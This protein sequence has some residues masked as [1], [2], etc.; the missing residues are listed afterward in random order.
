MDNHSLIN[1][2]VSGYRILDLIGKGGMGTVYRGMHTETGQQV[3]VK[4]LHHPG[5]S[6]RFIN[7]AKLHALLKHRNIAR[8]YGY[9]LVD[10]LPCIIMEYIE[11]QGLQDFFQ[12]NTKIPVEQSVNYFIQLCSAI[13]YLHEKDI[14]HRDIKPEN[15][16]VQPNQELKL[17]D[18]GIAKSSYSPKLTLAGFTVGTVDFMAPEHIRGK[19]EKASDIWSLGVI[20][21]WMLS[22]HLPFPS[23]SIPESKINTGMGRYPPVTKYLSQ[24]TREIDS[25]IASCL[26]QNPDSRANCEELLTQVILL[27]KDLASGNSE[28]GVIKPIKWFKSLNLP[29]WALPSIL[30]VLAILA[31]II[32]TKSPAKSGKSIVVQDSALIDSIKINVINTKN[33]TIVFPDQSVYPVPFTLKG[34]KDEQSTF[35]ITAPGFQDMPVTIDLNQRRK[36]F[37]YVLQKEDK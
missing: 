28:I 24:K 7:E 10:G 23:A 1:R 29:S 34:T 19:P 15:I 9:D 5:M 21:Y 25:I 12:N 32:I 37:E 20:L 35:I 13:S 26:D 4:I 18:F 36:T 2:I 14:I 16:K 17:L 30:L 22:G 31:V 11:G 8:M 33:A 27:E 6:E 3:A